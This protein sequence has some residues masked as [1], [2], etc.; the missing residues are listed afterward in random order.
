[1]ITSTETITIRPLGPADAATVADLHAGMPDADG[2]F[3]NLV[4]RPT[5]LPNV[6]R[7]LALRDGA[8]CV[9]GAFA[10]DRIVGLGSFVVLGTTETAEVAIVIDHHQDDRTGAFG[11]ELLHR[12]VHLARERGIARFVAELIPANTRMMRLVADTDFTVTAYRQNGI[13]RVGIQL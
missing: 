9:L 4:P 12:L 5:E 11:P 8:H 10:G 7:A 6:A 2:L 3:R 13:A 1:M